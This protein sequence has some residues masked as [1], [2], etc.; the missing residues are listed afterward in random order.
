MIKAP[1]TS[2]SAGPD[3]L[4]HPTSETVYPERSINRKLFN[5]RLSYLWRRCLHLLLLDELALDQDIDLVADDKLAIEH[6][7]ECQAKVPPVNPALGAVA[8]PVAH[9]AVIEIPV[10]HRLQRHRLGVALDGQVARHGVAILSGLFDPGD[11]EVN[12]GILVDFQKIG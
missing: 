5:T 10:L 7:A 4:A 11:F 2:R 9:H 12:R 3:C 8:E 6:H 1:A